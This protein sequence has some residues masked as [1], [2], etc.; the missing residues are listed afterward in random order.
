[1]T[2]KIDIGDYVNLKLDQ[3][4]MAT[5][6]NNLHNEHYSNQ[7]RG[8]LMMDNLMEQIENIPQTQPQ[9]MM[10]QQQQQM[11]M[12]QP[13]Q[14]M[15]MQQPQQQMM[16]Q[17]PQQQMMMQQNIPI[18]LY[19]NEIEDEKNKVLKDL[20]ITE[21]DKSEIKIIKSNNEK[22]DV[23]N[24]EIV[25]KKPERKSFTSH[26]KETILVILLYVIIGND[27]INSY[28]TKYIPYLSEIPLIVFIIKAILIGSLFHLIRWFMK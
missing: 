11:M 24:K 10:M 17:Q 28:I 22:K 19:N 18:N 2:Q 16:M 25:E 6:L 15:M 13:Q 26:I 12:Q 7:E 9:Q 20:D 14:Q 5:S 8:S 21:S 4:E 3:N 23:V 27:Y 1:M